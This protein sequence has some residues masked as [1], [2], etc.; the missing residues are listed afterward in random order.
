MF[1]SPG[2]GANTGSGFR[3]TGRFSKLP[4]LGMKLSHWPKFQKLHVYILFL[5]PRGSKLSFN[6]LSL[7]DQQFPGYGP[8]FKM[9]RFPDVP[10]VAQVHIY[11]L[12]TPSGQNWAYF[13][14]TSSGFRHT[15]QFQNCHIWAWNLPNWPKSS[16]SW[17]YT[18]FVSQGGG[19]FKIELIFARQAAV[20]KIRDFQNCHIWAWNLAIG[21][22]SRSCTYRLFLPQGGRNW[23]YF[24]STDSG[25]RDTGQFSNCHIWAWNLAIGQ[26]SKLHIL[27][28][29]AFVWLVCVLFGRAL[30]WLITRT[31]MSCP[32]VHEVATQW[33]L[34]ELV[35][36][37]GFLFGQRPPLSHLSMRFGSCFLSPS[38]KDTSLYI[39]AWWRSLLQELS[40]AVG[41]GHRESVICLFVQSLSS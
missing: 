37:E 41:Q 12:S 29:L 38:I 30:R 9:A 39:D 8:I 22:S 36:Q 2:G 32:F 20:S 21:Q 26:S 7:Y 3:D 6:I 34:S 18:V 1:L 15:D 17:T 14:S 19:V 16:R 10:E 5:P 24:R 23:T 13:H 33:R 31:T 25:F 40:K 35:C 11:T 28:F 4:Y 27:C